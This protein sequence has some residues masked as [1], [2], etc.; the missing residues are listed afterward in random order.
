MKL[1]TN[2]T[3]RLHFSD[4]DPLRFE[5]LCLNLISRAEIWKELNHFGRKGD[6]SGVDI[7]G[8][9]IVGE[10]EKICHVQ[11]KR[12]I[13]ITKND[14]QKVIA[15][16]ATN[17]SFPDKLLLIVSCDVSRNL[18]EY[19]KTY[20]KSVG[21]KES[22]IWTA[23]IIEAKLYKEYQDLLFIY[24]GI[25][26]EKEVRSNA[27]KI[28]HS[29][30]MEK[31]V[32]NKLIRRDWLMQGD[33]W[34]KALYDPTLKF[35]SSKVIIRSID[36][37]TYPKMNEPT[38]GEISPWFKTFFYNTYH[39]GIELWF[40][41]MMGTSIIVDA[42]GY[43]DL[44]E[45]DDKRIHNKKFQVVRVKTIGRIPYY[46]IVDFKPDGDQ[47]TSEPHLFCKFNINGM[48][49][50]EIYYRSEGDPSKELPDWD[51]DRTKRTIFPKD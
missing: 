48:P 50:E 13:K 23:S 6:D 9:K 35:I 21:I 24:F 5:D 44:A 34:K 30:G 33:N 4:L 11:C 27:A 38:K 14:L 15:K 51:L 42:N 29:I 10:L 32:H 2:T 41:P 25:Q 12:Y 36:D 8:I 19:F 22:E 47:Y 39:N 28:K 26:L 17:N 49:Y 40:D 31:K 16:I 46:N 43:W 7:L 45:Y 20:S 37:T 18:N 3:N 1:P